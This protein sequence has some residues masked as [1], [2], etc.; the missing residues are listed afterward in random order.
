MTGTR[1][2][3]AKQFSRFADAASV[4]ACGTSFITTRRMS[5]LRSFAGAI[6][7]EPTPSFRRN[8]I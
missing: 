5:S 8:L 2:N 4:R 1:D 3:P 7:T 6:S